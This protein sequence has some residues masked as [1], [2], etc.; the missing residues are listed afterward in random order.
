MPSLVLIVV[1]L[2]VGALLAVGATFATTEVLT[3]PPTPSNQ[4]AYNYGG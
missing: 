3:K 1:S 2:V 4:P